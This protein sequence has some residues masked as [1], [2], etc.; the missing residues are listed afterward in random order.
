MVAA[1]AGV[2]EADV[3]DEAKPRQLR[4]GPLERP[5]GYRVLS[6]QMAHG[7]H[8]FRRSLEC[9]KNSCCGMLLVLIA[10]EQHPD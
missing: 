4:P 2:E 3:L 9:Q 10:W 5:S 8:R 6:F 1:V 7:R